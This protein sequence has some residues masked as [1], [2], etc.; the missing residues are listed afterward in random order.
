MHLEGVIVCL[1]THWIDVFKKGVW[2]GFADIDDPELKAL[3]EALP[4]IA[5]QSKAP[6]T[7]KKYSGVFVRRKK[8]DS[9]QSWFRGLYSKAY[10][11]SIVPKPPD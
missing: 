1:L 6:A 4:S 3:A 7:I 10:A 9:I 2:P 5:L 8:V 11:G